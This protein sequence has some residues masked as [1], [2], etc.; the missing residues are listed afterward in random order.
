MDTV[1][2]DTVLMDTGLYPSALY[3]HAWLKR[4]RLWCLSLIAAQSP[5]LLVITGTTLAGCLF[6]NKRKSGL[7]GPRGKRDHYLIAI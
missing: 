4:L 2:M 7:K 3:P 5:H 6:S 1:L